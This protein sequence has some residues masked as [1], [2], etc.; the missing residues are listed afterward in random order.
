[1][2]R[3]RAVG[4]PAVWHK[5]IIDFVESRGEVRA[6][7]IQKSLGIPR[8]S[9]YHAIDSLIDSGQMYWSSRKVGNYRFLKIKNTKQ[10]TGL[11]LLAQLGY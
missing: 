11:C 1:M 8:R 4:R 7:E 3:R 10:L 2:M 9:L 6:L 5:S